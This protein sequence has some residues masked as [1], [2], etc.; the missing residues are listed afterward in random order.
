MD[1]DAYPDLDEFFSD[2][3]GCYRAEIDSLYRAG[4]RYLQLD[5]TNLAYPAIRSCAPA[6]KSGETSPIGCPMP[7]PPSSTR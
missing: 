7:M 4:C 2:L 3:A 1:I 6:P 5:D